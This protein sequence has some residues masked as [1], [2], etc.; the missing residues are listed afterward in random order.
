MAC[1]HGQAYPGLV[2][3]V[4]LSL[5]FSKLKATVC[6]RL[7]DIL[8][9][10]WTVD[11]L[12]TERVSQHLAG[13]FAS[14]GAVEIDHQHMTAGGGI[15]E[16]VA[17]RLH[18]LEEADVWGTV[19]SLVVG[20]ELAAKGFRHQAQA[21]LSSQPKTIAFGRWQGTEVI[22]FV[23]GHR[24]GVDAILKV[25]LNAIFAK[26]S[27]L[28]RQGVAGEGVHG[29]H[30]VRVELGSITVM[31]QKAGFDR[32]RSGDR[33]DRPVGSASETSG[34]GRNAGAR[35]EGTAIGKTVERAAGEDTGHRSTVLVV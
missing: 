25:E 16:E 7:I 34:R 35:I 33:I 32:A 9:P 27:Q 20:A 18:R 5:D 11:C 30:H 29:W 13:K 6:S 17:G 4:P 23:E 19:E 12:A 22:D 28:T 26:E 1:R 24:H 3:V 2:G 15:L 31:K 10:F 14:L 21:G 8:V